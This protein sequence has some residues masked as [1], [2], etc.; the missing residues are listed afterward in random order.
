MIHKT[1]LSPEEIESWQHVS[2]SHIV[3]LSMPKSCHLY[4][5]QEIHLYVS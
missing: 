3:S 4:I 1:S 2:L 5:G